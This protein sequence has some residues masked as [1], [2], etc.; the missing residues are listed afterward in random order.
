MK[1]IIVL[2]GLLVISI[3]VNSDIAPA[4]IILKGIYTNIPCEI[5]MVSEVVNVDLYPD[6]S[7]VTCTFQMLNHGSSIE[8]PVGFPMMNFHH[9]NHAEYQPTDKD[10]FRI[11]VDGEQLTRDQIYVP[12]EMRN[13]YDEYMMVFRADSI[14]KAKSDSI[15]SHYR[16]KHR[17]NSS[18]YQPNTYEVVN[19]ELEKLFK[20]R[21]QQPYLGSELMNKFESA[22]KNGDNLWYI[23]NV[24]F[25]QNSERT[26]QVTYSVPTGLGYGGQHRYFKYLLSTGQ[27]WHLDIEKAEVNVRLIDI[28]SRH[29]EEI[30][31]EHGYLTSG[32][33]TVKWTFTSLEPSIEDDIFLKYYIPHVPKIISIFSCT[34]ELVH[35]L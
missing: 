19:R 3:N 27:G 21:D 1:K 7:I 25:D 33:S 12:E 34:F 6:S 15:Y 2:L 31:P 18:I 8:L 4:Q 23:W 35:K 13:V 14:Y 29:I 9:W 20:W 5:Q 22:A 28:S 26:I 24:Q 30:Y 16:V 10:Y 11:N 32:E 17:K